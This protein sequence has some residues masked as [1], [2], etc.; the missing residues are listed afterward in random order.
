[1]YQ[2]VEDKEFLRK[3]KSL[4]GDIINQLVQSI[5]NDEVMTVEAHLVGSGA[6]NLITQ[7]A[8]EPVDLDDNL[9]VL[10]V[11]GISFNDGKAIKEHIQKHFNLILKKFKLGNCKDSTSVLS[12]TYISFKKGNPTNFKIDLAIVREINYY[13]ER[14][15][16]QKTGWVQCDQWCWNMA[17]NS[18]GLIDRVFALKEENLWLE[19]RVR[20]LEKK[21]MYL[22][23]GEKQNHPS[24]NVYIETINEIYYEYFQ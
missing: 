12:T 18:R 13:W 21:N 20:Y 1:M 3:M 5:N 7:N 16:H 9:C 4:C 15:I 17:P 19:V 14:L 23:R 6:K 10:D 8:K 2:Y 22:C 11:Y 24:F